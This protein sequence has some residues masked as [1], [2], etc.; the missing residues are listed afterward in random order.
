MSLRRIESRDNTYLKLA[1]KVR[2]GR[3]EDQIFVE[4]LRLAEEA[5]SSDIQLEFCLVREGFDSNP[6]ANSLLKAIA[7]MD[8]DILETTD[9]VFA[10]VAATSSSQGIVL[11]GERP[12]TDAV[13]FEKR[14]DVTN[15]SLPLLVMLSEANDPS[16]VGAVLRTAEAASVLGVV[17]GKN[18]ADVFSPK[19]LRSSMGS[20]FR[21]P[22]WSG[23]DWT[24]IFEW[25]G[26][27]GFKTVATSATGA[28]NYAALDWN[29]PRLLVLGSEAH[30]LPDEL[31]AIVDDLISI[32]MQPPVES[33]NLAVA[34]GVI[35]FEARRQVTNAE[36]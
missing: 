9:Q 27:S 19:A 14:I 2:D 13:S 25:A 29:E 24:E 1:R 6:R 21:M 18:S 35:M 11:I 5:V 7:E 26:K 15:A 16:N 8:V 22:V 32:P 36:K 12:P 17:I 3:E 33:L 20:A 28:T 4:G 31:L 10:T 23:A 34:A 30:G